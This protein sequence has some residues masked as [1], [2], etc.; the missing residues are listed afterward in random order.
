MSLLRT[1]CVALDESDPVL[2]SAISVTTQL[3]DGS[4]EEV[5]AVH[6]I[7]RLMADEFGSTATVRVRGRSLTVRF[8]RA[9]RGS[10]PFSN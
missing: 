6:R 3:A 7:S 4:V 1:H 2:I 8:A 5:D 10:A 9:A